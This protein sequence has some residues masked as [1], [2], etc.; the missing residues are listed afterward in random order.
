[1][2][3]IITAILI[4]TV[5]LNLY[6]K[7]NSNKGV[8][9]YNLSSFPIQDISVK[10]KNGLL[11]MR[12]E[13]KLARDV[14]LFLYEKWNMRIFK[15]IA[16]SEQT[17]MNAV[18]TLLKRYSID[19]PVE[20]DKRGLFKDENLQKLYNDLTA[21]G[22]KSLNSALMMGAR[23]EELDIKDL[24]ILLKET[25]NRDITFVYN[26]LL[27]G[28]SNHLRAFDKQMKRNKIGYQSVYISQKDYNRIV[29]SDQE[30][31]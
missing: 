10:E 29:S 7:G 14:Y 28:S 24:R 16:E 4:F 8:N 23:I 21:E 11:L 12:E 17:H 20:R 1:M 9:N 22:S 27:K 5:S 25:D 31:R 13:E 3:K 6:S 30:R 18:K 2:N 26:N 15:N 19:D